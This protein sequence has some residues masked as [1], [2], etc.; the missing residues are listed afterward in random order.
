M[1][2][3]VMTALY[4]TVVFPNH[5]FADERQILLGSFHNY[6]IKQCDSFI[7]ENSVLKSNWNFFINKHAGGIDGPTTEVTLTRI[8]GNVG[9][10]VK[11]DDTYIQT[12]KKCFLRTSA[13]FTYPGPCSDSI[14]GNSWYV[15]NEMPN[16]DYTAYK[17]SSGVEMYAKEISVGNFK[18]CIHEMSSRNIGSHG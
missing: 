11:I 12:A 10:T 7:L 5:A 8:F 13:T 3:I 17:S 6:G 9:D 15:Y 18:A 4:F 16:K 14:D 2:R 1:K